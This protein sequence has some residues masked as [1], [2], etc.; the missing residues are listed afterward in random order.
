MSAAIDGVLR[1][2]AISPVPFS[3]DNT[4]IA[5]GRIYDDAKGRFADG[6]PIRTSKIVEGP[7]ADG[8]IVTR[9]SRYRLE[10]AA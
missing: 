5:T 9:N 8:V 6:T 7:D 3:T 10:M 4:F 2:A 1:S